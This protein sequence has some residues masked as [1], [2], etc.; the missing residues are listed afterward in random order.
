[1][2]DLKRLEGVFVDLGVPYEP[3]AD[4]AAGAVLGCPASARKDLCVGIE[5]FVF[6]EQGAFLGVADWEFMF[7]KPRVNSSPL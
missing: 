3:G 7:F 6:D 1:M 2:T 5:S 4:F